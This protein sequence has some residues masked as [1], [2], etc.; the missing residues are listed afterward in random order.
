[1]E[2]AEDAFACGSALSLLS[3]FSFGFP[4]FEIKALGLFVDQKT[5]EVGCTFELEVLQFKEF[6][7]RSR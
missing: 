1:M 4:H 2:S 3:T 7:Y 6:C 5:G